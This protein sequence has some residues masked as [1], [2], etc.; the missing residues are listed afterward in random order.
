[1]KNKKFIAALIAASIT[2]GAMPSTLVFANEAIVISEESAQDAADYSAEYNVEVESFTLAGNEDYSKAYKVSGIKSYSNNGGKYGASTLDK[3]FDGNTATHW[4]TGKPNSGTHTNEVIVTFN[5]VEEINRIVY[6]ART[7]ASQKG[8]ATKFSIYASMSETGDDFELVGKGKAA[9]VSGLSEFKFETTSFKRLKFVFDEAQNY[10]ASAS[11]FM[12]YKQDLVS[13]KVADLFTNGLM[14]E[15][16][17]E[18]RSLEV[19]TALEAEVQK[20]PLRESMMTD[21]ETAKALLTNL[22]ETTSQRVVTGEQRGA[23]GKGTAD[24]YING[25]AYASFESFGKYVTAGETITV[26]VDADPNGVM[27]QLCFGQVGKG[28]GD[29]RRWVTLKPGKNVITAPTNINPSALY[30]VNNADKTQQAYAPRVRVEGGTAFPTYFHGETDPEAFYEELKAYAENIEYEDAAFANGNPAGKV[31]NI[32]EF[33]SENCVITTSAMGAIAGLDAAAQQG[34]NIGDTMDSWEEMYDMFQDFLGLE[35]DAEEVKHS[36]FPN[37]FVARVFQNVPLG[38]ADHGYTGYLGSN[39]AE[40]VG[41]F[42]NLIAMPIYA[43]YN[44]NWCYNHEIGHIFNT[45]YI[46]HGEVTN[47]LFAQE[48]RRIKGLGGDRA[49]WNGILKRFQGE[50]V[51]LGFWTNLAILSQLNIGYGYDAYAKASR[52]VRDHIDVIKN[53]Q[54]GELRRLAVAYSLGLGVDLLDFFED[55]KYTDVTPEMRAAVSHLPKE[56]RKIEYLHNGAYDYAGTGFSEAVK[57]QATTNI[58]TQTSETVLKFSID[59]EN[60]DDLLGY[61][62]LADGEVIGFTRNNSFTIKESNV[63]ENMQYEIV[64]YAKDLTT[65]KAIMVNTFAPALSVADHVTLSL[66]ETFNPLDYAAAVSYNGADLEILNV[67]HNVDVSKKGNYEVKYTVT[68]NGITLTK[69]MPITVVSEYDYLSD[70][71]WTSVSTQW[72]TPRRNTDIKGRQNGQ[73]KTYEKGIGIHANGEIVYDLGEHNY[74]Q[75]E[76]FVGVDMT[77]AAQDYSSVKFKVLVDG[78]ELAATNVLK[79]SDNMAYISVPITGARELKI[80]VDN[81]GNGN[82]SDHGVIVNPKLTNNNAKPLL[83]VAENFTTVPLNS[84][85][86]LREGLVARDAEDG[87]LTGAVTIDDGGLNL[88]KS[89]N[90][91][92]TYTVS[93]SDGNTE[94][95]TRKV[96]VYSAADFASD[97][98]WSS[99]TTEYKTVNKDKNLSGGA[100]SLSQEGEVITFNK[101][102]GIHANGEVVYDLR[103]KKFEAFETYI[104]VEQSVGSQDKSSIIFKVFADEKEVYNSGLMKYN[105]PAKF[106]SLDLEGVSTLRLVVDNGGNGNSFDHATFGDAKFLMTDSAPSLTVPKDVAL[107]VGETLEDIFGEYSAQDAEEGDLTSK[108]SVSG[109]VNFRQP[110]KYTVTYTVTDADGNETIAER[111]I[112]VVDMEDYTYVSDADWASASCGWGSIKKDLSPSG[113]TIRLT[114]INNQEV[115]FEKGLGTHAK[116]TVVYD[117]TSVDA[118]FF[119]AYVG[120]DRAMYGTVGSV[121]F[122]V[123]LDGTKVE[124]T[125]VITS[126][127]AMKYLEVNLAG[128]KELKIVAT[129]GG[130]GNGSDHAV[131]GDAK[132]HFA[133]PENVQPDRSELETYIETLN[134]LDSSRYTD[135]SWTALAEVKANAEVLLEAVKVTQTALDEAMQDL[136]AAQ[137]GLVLVG[138]K[139]ELRQL[140]AEAEDLKGNI[141]TAD[142]WNALQESIEDAKDALYGIPEQAVIDEVTKA[143]QTAME[144]LE[145]SVGKMA[146]KSAL[147]LAEDFTAEE[148]SQAPMW[149]DFTVLKAEAESIYLAVTLESEDTLINLA[150]DLQEVIS[151]LNVW[152]KEQAPKVDKTLLTELVNETNALDLRVYT[153]ASKVNLT[154]ATILANEMLA[155]SEAAQEEVDAAASALQ[156][157]LEQLE[158]SN[159]KAELKKVLDLAAT[160]EQSDYS[161]AEYWE[162]FEYCYNHYIDLYDKDWTEQELYIAHVYFMSVIEDL[163]RFGKIAVQ[164]ESI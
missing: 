48:Y 27:P 104:G 79:H 118:A 42:F 96:I 134:L 106:I 141:Y 31:F 161:N 67:S 150:N 80:I 54:G 107:K 4:E 86:D 12:F 154:E 158:I 135:E 76:A 124:D 90:Y 19:I 147:D 50:E 73:V 14:N 144:E 123:Y 109:D 43:K 64:A 143:L 28:Q 9:K 121:A 133:N 126:K 142:S 130:N 24:R 153:K 145:L 93:D 65:A 63:S 117:L 75:F 70:T 125:G 35:A 108:V 95:V 36:Q 78:E 105:T 30:L 112:S 62:I 69:T 1:M 52:A 139:T 164:E 21:I 85:L 131:W 92:V 53:I 162:V 88:A 23:Y 26:Y 41:G 103:D 66:G 33:V 60:Q 58:N 87:D 51:T 128:A 101:G 71:A 163:E 81:G 17:P 91:A 3:A 5:E 10:W 47:N 38:Y 22:S 82:A 68:D 97:I 159:G 140:L 156:E 129:D 37:K 115:K 7:D 99:A 74:E 89:G 18:Y 56:T 20:H 83:E 132:F 148:C 111:I 11:E 55:W 16:K 13:E 110:G 6:G 113:N 138:E 39:N 157:A 44:D 94:T 29:W 59:E 8:Y 40:R 160:K 46:V 2:A 151:S 136:R 155:T 127:A 32:A 57:V 61:E 120:V 98:E 77:I 34:Y 119:S 149:F 84:T 102:I 137:E 15:L 100:L 45:K 122:E 49:D 152:Q 146:L 116:S 25:N 72:G 114:D